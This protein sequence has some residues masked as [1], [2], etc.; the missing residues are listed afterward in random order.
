MINM[1]HRSIHLLDL[2]DE[3]LLIIMKKLKHN[4]I[5][6]SLLGVNKRLDR[7][8]GSKSNTDVINFTSMSSTAGYIRMDHELLDRFC[9]YIMPRIC[10]NVI[11][12]VLDHWSMKRVLLACK[13]SILRSIIFSCFQSD[14]FLNCLEGKE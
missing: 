3:L 13:Y 6:Y 2:P 7:L 5:L 8:A 4:D 12:L 9:F 14:I 10:H 1:K 11:I